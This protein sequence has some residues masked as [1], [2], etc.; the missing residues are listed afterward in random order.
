MAEVISFE[1][2]SACLEK[3]VITKVESRKLMVAIFLIICLC[4][5]NKGPHFVNE[6][7]Y[8]K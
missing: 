3:L 6:D 7:L 8:L 5:K 2:G 4:Y 1:A